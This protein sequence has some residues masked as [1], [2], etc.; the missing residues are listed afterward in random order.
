M[1][2]GVCFSAEGVEVL[3]TVTNAL[4]GQEGGAAFFGMSYLCTD[5]NHKHFIKLLEHTWAQ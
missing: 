3:G 5:Y 4:W 1:S 2:S